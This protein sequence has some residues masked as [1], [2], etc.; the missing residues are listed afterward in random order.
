MGFAAIAVTQTLKSCPQPVALVPL[1][2]QEGLHEVAV[3]YRELGQRPRLSR[4]F[5]G[6]FERALE[7]EPRHGVDVHGGDLAAEAHGF[8]RNSAAAGKRVQHLGRAPTVGFANLVAEPLERVAILPAPMKDAALGYLFGLLYDPAVQPFALGLLHHSASHA[9][10]DFLPFVV[11]A[12]VGE[13]C[14]NERGSRGCQGSACGPNVERGDVPMPY[15]LLV[16]RVERDLLEREGDFYEAFVVS[17]HSC[18]GRNKSDKNP[19]CLSKGGK[20]INDFLKRI[21]I[22]F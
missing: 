9:L 18:V 4:Q 7:D 14:G 8:K 6:V 13:E 1:G 19:L 5:L 2:F 21:G 12:R 3:G 10:Q 22:G 17:W 15:V 11:V 20:Y 16:H